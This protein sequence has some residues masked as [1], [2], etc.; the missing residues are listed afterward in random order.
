MVCPNCGHYESKVIDSRNTDKFSVRRRREC[1]ACLKRFTTYEVVEKVPIMIIKKD[2]RREIFDKAKLKAG[3]MKSCY[4]R[5]VTIEQIDEMI[6]QIE[7]ELN[8][9][10]KHE[11]LSSEI[12]TIVMNKLRLLDEVSYVRFAS[13]YRE[14]SDIETFMRE[15]TNIQNERTSRLTDDSDENNEESIINKENEEKSTGLRKNKKSLDK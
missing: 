15:L 6:L 5:P 13:V 3:I 4:K 2:E 8:N 14:F 10:T 7:K 11:Y 12:G 1:V 9:S